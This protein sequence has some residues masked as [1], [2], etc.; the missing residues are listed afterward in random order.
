MILR[1]V[2]FEDDDKDRVKLEEAFLKL[3]EGAEFQWF[4]TPLID[5]KVDEKRA[6]QIAEYAP[7][8]IILDLMD[9]KRKMNEGKRTL[10][11]LKESPYTKDIPVV[12]WSRLLRQKKSASKTR[13]DMINGGATA[14]R[15]ESNKKSL[16]ASMFLKAVGIAFP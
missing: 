10:R 3:P 5:W 1:V 9:D 15:K 13:I 11:Q 6:K 2:V 16:D 7:S 4:T 8:F 12:V 14:L